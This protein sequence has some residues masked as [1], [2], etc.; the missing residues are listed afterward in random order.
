MD[1]QQAINLALV[2]RFESEGIGF[3]YPTRTLFVENLPER[4]EPAK[5]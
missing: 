3:A 2:R 1:A 5:E 4:G